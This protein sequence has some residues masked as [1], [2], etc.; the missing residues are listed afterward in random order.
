MTRVL[1][2]TSPAG[3]APHPVCGPR[4]RRM[5]KTCVSAQAGWAG[6]IL[7]QVSAT[8]KKNHLAPG[9]ETSKLGGSIDRLLV[10]RA[11]LGNHP[12]SPF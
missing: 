4:C 12:G 7:A 10:G 8:R 2:P 6:E 5:G 1:S 11:Q 9:G 3:F